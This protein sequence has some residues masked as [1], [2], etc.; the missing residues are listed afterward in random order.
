MSGR[1]A[2]AAVAAAFAVT[3]LPAAPA[4]A[5]DTTWTV[6]PG[7]VF[8]GE[9]DNAAVTLG[10]GTRVVCGSSSVD[11][12][13]AGG[14]GLTNPLG[15]VSDLHLT[16]CQGWFDLIP[17]GD[18]RLI[19]DSF[20]GDVSHCR[21][22]DVVIDVAGPGCAATVTGY[23]NVTYTNSTGTWR[24]L[25]DPTL[26]VDVVD[27]VDNCLGLLATGDHVAVDAEFRN[28][29]TTTITSP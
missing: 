9:A 12:V 16:D 19:C 18:W 6:T 11:G 25:P 21:L 8:H 4:A 2:K 10:S 1:L 24:I 26:V 17:I 20:D 29:P 14:A 22:V 7:G 5:Q 15:T 3:L 13:L 23:L 28:L 27:P